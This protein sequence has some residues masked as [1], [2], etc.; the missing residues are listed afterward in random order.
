[1]YGVPKDFSEM[2]L[3]ITKYEDQGSDEMEKPSEEMRMSVENEVKVEELDSRSD[4]RS[5]NS[6]FG[7]GRTQYF[8]QT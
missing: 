7:R 1:M 5:Q 3:E 2:L 6:M 8:S 4:V